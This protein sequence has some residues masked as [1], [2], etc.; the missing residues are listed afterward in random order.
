ME[1]VRLIT[2]GL[3]IASGD[4][5]DIFLFDDF[6]WTDPRFDGFTTDGKRERLMDI[7]SPQRAGLVLGLSF[8]SV[9]GTK[10]LDINEAIH[11][12]PG[13]ADG[14]EVASGLSITAATQKVYSARFFQVPPRLDYRL[15]LSG[16]GSFTL[17]A[18]LQAW[19]LGPL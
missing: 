10:G 19:C 18:Y 1:R 17:T 16:S 7:I 3:A 2:D 13:Y 5:G 8:A 9:S 4:T 15:T 6:T 11:F 14:T 12:G